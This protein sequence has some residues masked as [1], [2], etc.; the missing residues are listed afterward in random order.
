MA[1]WCMHIQTL[2]L[3]VWSTEKQQLPEFVRHVESQIPPQTQV[4]DLHL[5]TIPGDPY[6]Q[7]VWEAV[8]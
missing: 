3:K 5:I 8:L 2:L 1:V 6:A 7:E 4:Q